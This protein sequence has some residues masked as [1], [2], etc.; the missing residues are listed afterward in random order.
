MEDSKCY[1]VQLVSLYSQ[2]L[3]YAYKCDLDKLWRDITDF[4]RVITLE[5]NIKE[6]HLRGAVIDEINKLKN[7]LAKTYELVC[8]TC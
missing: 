4:D 2:R 1:L 6:C 7:K 8:R 5:E 3:L